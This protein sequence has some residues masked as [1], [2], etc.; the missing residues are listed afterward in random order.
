MT[1]VD[2]RN[3]CART[4]FVMRSATTPAVSLSVSGSR[5]TNSS[6]PTRATTSPPRE[7]RISTSTSSRKHRVA[8]EM[9]RRIVDRL[10]VIDVDR[11]QR[12]LATAARR[13]SHRLLEHLIEPAAI[14]AAGERIGVH[15][16]RELGPQMVVRVTER[17][18]TV[19]L[20]ILLFD[21]RA[22]EVTALR[23]REQIDEHRETTVGA[24]VQRHSVQR[25][26]QIDRD[27]PRLLG[28]ADADAALPRGKQHEPVPDRRRNHRREGRRPAEEQLGVLQSKQTEQ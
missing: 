10:E 3:L 28:P 22:R 26:E 8:G 24:R 2:V 16:R 19:R 1:A 23:G 21:E 20:A 14:Q 13:R 17:G 9:A 5:M 12:H 11:E 7:D 25:D 27:E 4:L 6:P 15:H 18:D